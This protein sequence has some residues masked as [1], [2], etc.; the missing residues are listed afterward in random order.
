[1]LAKCKQGNK[2]AYSNC[3]TKLVLIAGINSFLPE[4]EWSLVNTEKTTSRPQDYALN[5]LLKEFAFLNYANLLI[6]REVE[7]ESSCDK[8]AKTKGSDIGKVLT[9]CVCVNWK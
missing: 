1:M 9:K 6:G 5:G 2:H 4:F 7:S 3:K 8:R